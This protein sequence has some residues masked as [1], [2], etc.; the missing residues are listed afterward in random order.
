MY[1]RVFCNGQTTKFCQIG[2]SQEG[3]FDQLASHLVTLRQSD[4]VGQSD[5]VS[6]SDLLFLAQLYNK[7]FWDGQKL[8]FIKLVGQKD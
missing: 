3:V 4:Q 5:Q 8:I 1:K 2:W 6:Q 7:V